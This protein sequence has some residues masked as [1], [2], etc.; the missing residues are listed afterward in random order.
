MTAFD[1]VAAYLST[2]TWDAWF[3]IGF[4]GQAIFFSRF[5]VQWVASERRGVSYVPR[6]FWWLSIGG[7]LV[8]L[9]YGLHRRD[10]VFILAYLFNC[11]PYARNLMLPPAREAP[12]PTPAVPPA[13]RTP[14]AGERTL[15]IV[16]PCHDEAL[17]VAPL[18]DAVAAA[19]EG[20]E[21]EW[22]LLLVDDA[23]RDD[24][25]ARA[26]AIAAADPRVRVLE[27][28]RRVGQTGA[29]WAGLRAARGAVLCTIDADLQNDPADLPLLLSRLTEADAVCGWRRRRGDGDDA[30]RRVS[31]RVANGVRD[32][33]T[34][35]AVKDSGCCFRVM[36]R[37]CLDGLQLF[38]GL[39][40]FLPTLLRAQGWRLVE[41]EVRHH[42]RRAGRAKYGVLNRVFKATRDLFAVRWMLRRWLRPVVARSAGRGLVPAVATGRAAG[43]AAAPVDPR[44]APEDASRDA[45]LLA[46]LLENPVVS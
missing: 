43:G 24:T 8:L 37:E 19:L 3:V 1:G 45:Q 27:L 34:G 40:R 32:A 17:N 30:L 14:C 6:A 35:D 28:E 44:G 15:S 41:V 20:A 16:A 26:R 2:L 11:L 42:P 31:S 21:L 12:P 23:S 4:V 46:A 5:L 33:L 25:A 13:P 9:A 39:H 38:D 7:S 18:R 22:E 29:M 10:P 36:R